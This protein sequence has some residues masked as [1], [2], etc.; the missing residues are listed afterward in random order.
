MKTD[1]LTS[2]NE[3]FF[4]EDLVMFEKDKVI[5]VFLSNETTEGKNTTTS[6]TVGLGQNMSRDKRGEAVSAIISLVNNQYSFLVELLRVL[7]VMFKR[8]RLVRKRLLLLMSSDSKMQ[9]GKKGSRCSP[10][11]F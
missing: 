10:H 6:F 4:N 1:N 11:R 8:K 5:E 2:I 7:T 9:N 3:I